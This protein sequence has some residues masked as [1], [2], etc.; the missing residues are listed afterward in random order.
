MI[1]IL[2]DQSEMMFTTNGLGRLSDCLK[3]VVTEERDGIYECE[4]DY[5][6]TGIHYDD[7]EEGKVIYCIHDDTKR[8]QAFDIYKRS[9]PMNGV[10]TFY[11]HHVSYRLGNVI[12]KPFTASSCAQVF[13]TLKNNTINDCEFDF[14]T[15]KDVT[16]Q[17][18]IDRPI[19]IKEMLGGTSG[20]VLDV[21]GK[22]E[23]EWD[24]FTVKLY[25]NRGRNLPIQIRYGKNLADINYEK[26]ILENYSA[27]APFW[28]GP[29][30]DVVMLPEI[31][32]TAEN[33]PTDVAD[34][35]DEYGD[36]LIAESG[37]VLEALTEIIRPV[38]LDLSE[39]F[40]EAP[41]EN[42]LRTA[43]LKS[44]NGAW[45]P[46]I[47]IEIDFDQL[48]QTPEYEQYAP[49][50]RASLC[51]RVDVYYQDLGLIAY[52]QQIIETRY[53]VLMERYASMELGKAQT[54]FAQ[55]LRASV[56]SAILQQVPSKT[57]LEQSVERATSLITGGLGGHVVIGVNADG[58]PNE[59]LVMDTDDIAT[60]VNVLR[61][62]YQG[63]GFSSTGY[64]GPFRS[65]WTLDGHFV[66]DFIDTG[67]LTANLLRTGIISDKQGRN[68]WNL[69]TGE[70]SITLD[71][72]EEGEVTRADLSRVEANAQAYADTAEENAKAYVDGLDIMTESEVDNKISA[73]AAGMES[74]FSQ[75]YS[76][77]GD[78]TVAVTPYYYTSTSP[79]SLYGGQWSANP[80]PWQEGFYVWRKDR[81]IKGDGTYTETTPVC[82]TGNTGIGVPG[83]DGANGADGADGENG[84]DALY[85]YWTADNTLSI[86]KEDTS[87]VSI[88]AHVG[89]GDS[90]DIDPT[91]V[92]FDYA[93]FLSRD[94]G[95]TELFSRGKTV[96]VSIDSYLCSDRADVWFGLAEEALFYIVDANGTAIIDHDGNELEVA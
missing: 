37:E 43:A 20:S 6:V 70:F 79:T 77:K 85:L 35:I 56:E 61:I 5:P 95:A 62:N 28:K 50:M 1:P 76:T 10:T 2:Y 55:A 59:I 17:Y 92:R 75:E 82:L 58:Q 16:S 30:G 7:I 63:I 68:Y 29:E 14:W 94:N 86:P 80:D 15:D 90:D 87:T 11:A 66:A 54:S 96:V 42:A 4:F 89:Q 34:M 25:L 51:D 73:S 78:T 46:D 44:L 65:A 67:M 47:N 52:G 57:F 22:G 33:L 81:Y 39:S 88:T 38:P 24:M 27:V 9:A 3:C 72:G 84:S 18:I 41:T 91:G 53:D 93:W 36:Y 26:S 69:D 83:A 12:L 45:D 13:A 32:V 60:A 49:L 48:W 31:I 64:N 8:P 23:Y 19:S 21:Y 71:P 74:R 40:E